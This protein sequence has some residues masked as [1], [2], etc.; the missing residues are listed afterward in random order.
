MNF[1]SSSA[2]SSGLP[3]RWLS[4]FSSA[5]IR[6]SELL[7]LGLASVVDTSSSLIFALPSRAKGADT[8]RQ[9]AREALRPLGGAPSAQ[10]ILGVVREISSAATVLRA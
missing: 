4:V 1:I 8:R 5:A 9:A 3:G 2:T 10:P 6:D 7:F